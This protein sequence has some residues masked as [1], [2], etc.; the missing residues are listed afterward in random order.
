MVGKCI[1]TMLDPPHPFDE[2]VFITINFNNLFSQ[3][4]KEIKYNLRKTL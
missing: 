1:S 3:T 2:S 4:D